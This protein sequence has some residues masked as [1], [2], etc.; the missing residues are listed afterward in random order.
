MP[1]KATLKQALGSLASIDFLEKLTEYSLRQKAPSVSLAGSE[2]VAAQGTTWSEVADGGRRKLWR[3]TFDRIGARDILLLEFSVFKGDSMREFITLN[4]SPDS[5]FFG[6]D[7]FEGLPEVWRGTSREH[8]SVH[9][10]FPDIA[11]SRVRFVKGWFNKTLEPMLDELA[12]LARGRQVIVHFDADLYS[13]SLYLLFTLYR[14]FPDYVFIFDEFDGHET[15]ALYNFVQAT[16]AGTEFFHHV[17]WQGCPTSVSG[18]L[19]A[20]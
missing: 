3:Q 15:R 10:Q 16:G 18:R 20:G 11:D 13:S 2:A 7:S 9:G 12:E 19:T 6:F 1:L 8:F 4:T 17:L 5:R 14:R